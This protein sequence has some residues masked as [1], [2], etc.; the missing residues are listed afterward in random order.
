[1]TVW[2]K[3]ENINS[4]DSKYKNKH[5]EKCS[6]KKCI[7]ILTGIQP[8]VK[9]SAK[10]KGLRTISAGRELPQSGKRLTQILALCQAMTLQIIEFFHFASGKI[11]S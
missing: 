9:C 6:I 7:K 4:N 11:E 8:C 3:F 10:C 5:L 2:S 1:M